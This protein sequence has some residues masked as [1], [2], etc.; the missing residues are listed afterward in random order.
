[1]SIRIRGEENSHKPS[2]TGEVVDC[3]AAMGALEVVAVEI[4]EINEHVSQNS[5]CHKP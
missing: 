3:E 4:N 2:G 5:Q 1:M